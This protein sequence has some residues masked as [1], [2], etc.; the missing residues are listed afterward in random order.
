[1]YFANKGISG[2]LVL[3]LVI[4]IGI[5]LLNFLPFIL[6][7]AAVVIGVNYI[8]KA[9]KKWDNNRSKI[10]NTKAEK[11]KTV[12]SDFSQTYTSGNV[13]DVEYTEVK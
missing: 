13:I 5:T 3:A 11:A 9:F 10:F 12:K 1:M 4:I 7:I 6:L 2:F 8:I